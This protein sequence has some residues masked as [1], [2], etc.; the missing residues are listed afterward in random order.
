M[1]NAPD[2]IQD[3]MKNKPI[4]SLNDEALSHYKKYRKAVEFLQKIKRP[5]SPDNIKYC[6]TLSNEEMLKATE[7][8]GLAANQIKELEQSLNQLDERYEKA[9]EVSNPTS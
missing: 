2:I 8:L 9:K 1:L 5:L 7:E 3:R 6:K 4:P